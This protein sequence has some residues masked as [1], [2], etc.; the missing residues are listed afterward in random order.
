MTADPPPADPFPRPHPVGVMLNSVALVLALLA[1]AMLG[2]RGDFGFVIVGPDRA[3]WSG[4]NLAAYVVPGDFPG[5]PPGGQRTAAFTL[6]DG[7]PVGLPNGAPAPRVTVYGVPFTGLSAIVWRPAGGGPVSRV[8]LSLSVWFLLGFGLSVGAARLLL[9]A[10]RR[11]AGDEPRGRNPASVAALLVGLG[12]A[13]V[14]PA[15]FVGAAL[16][17]LPHP[18]YSLLVVPPVER[19][20]AFVTRAPFFGGGVVPSP[21]EPS[22]SEPGPDGG[23]PAVAISLP[24]LGVPL[25]FAVPAAALLVAPVLLSG[26]AV[27][28]WRRRRAANGGHG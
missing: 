16:L 6:A 25:S 13:W 24:G 27:L 3:A 4:W 22:P 26:V 18:L 1:A 7:S 20:S 21:S 8:T 9:A 28:R 10:A 15:A 11:G 19:A 23:W 17:A 12:R 5:N 2:G 14:W